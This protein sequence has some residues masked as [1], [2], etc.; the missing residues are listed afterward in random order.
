MFINGAMFILLQQTKMKKV[1]IFAGFLAVLLGMQLVCASTVNFTSPTE[2]S[3]KYLNVASIVI[4]VTSADEN[5]TNITISL[6]NSTGIVNQTTITSAPF[7][8][9]FTNLTNGIYYFNATAVN[10]SS[11]IINVT[12]TRN[13]TVDIASPTINFTS[14]SSSAGSQKTKDILVNIST[15]D[16]NLGNVTLNISKSGWSNKTVAYG[17]LY[18][19]FSNLTDGTYS[20]SVVVNDSAGNVNSTTRVISIDTVL[21]VIH[22]VSPDDNDEWTSDDQI[23]FEFNVTDVG[24]IANCS[25]YIDGKINNTETGI[26]VGAIEHIYSTSMDDGPYDWYISCTDNADN[27]DTSE[28]L[29]LDL[30]YDSGDGGDGGG[31]GGG[32]DDSPSFWKNTYAPTDEQLVVGYFK[33]LV[34]GDRVKVKVINESHYVGIINVSA[35][36]IVINV[37]STPQQATLRVDETKKFEVTNDSYYDVSVTLNS[38]NGTKANLTVNYIHEEMPEVE[39]ENVVLGSTENRTLN[40]TETEKSNVTVVNWGKNLSTGKRWTLMVIILVVLAAATITYYI[41]VFKKRKRMSGVKIRGI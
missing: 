12:E 30:N 11:D 38:I 35:N 16:S 37:S 23:K 21:P 6:F 32:G 17:S 19:N 3:G 10:S 31:G 14:P 34:K 36:E 8:V 26:T 40:T 41:F 33:V 29:S 24:G 13:L 5:L 27:T 28:T 39:E 20:I 7:F 22:L 4:N 1:L 25:V 2:D 18:L 9:N 15:A